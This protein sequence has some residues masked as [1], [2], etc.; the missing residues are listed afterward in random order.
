MTVIKFVVIGVLLGLL[1]VARGSPLND[2]S[3][4]IVGGSDAFPGQFPHIVSLRTP[5]YAHFCG[6]SLV[7][8]SWVLTSAHCTLGRAND[9]VIVIAGSVHLS[10]GGEERQ[11]QRI[12]NHPYFNANTMAY[13]ISLIHTVTAFPVTA[14]IFPI[15]M[16]NYTLPAGITGVLS[17]WGH[18]SY[19][20]GELNDNQQWLFVKTIS[21]DDCRSRVPEIDR[22][23]VHDNTLCTARENP[24]LGLCLGN[25]GGSIL[26]GNAIVAVS[27]WHLGC[28][29]G[30]PDNH[31]LVSAH[32]PWIHTTMMGG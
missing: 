14:H 6:G 10:E 9:G 2:P 15:A 12:A 30:Y 25:L 8:V 31:A 17:A 1:A 3:S 20:D 27:S 23:F 13:D 19:P 21:L 26:V 5:T 29:I 7:S 4:R 22:P 24:G 28:A 32:I 18:T 16:A 11:S